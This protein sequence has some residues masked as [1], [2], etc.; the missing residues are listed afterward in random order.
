VVSFPQDVLESIQ[1]R[2]TDHMVDLLREGLQQ[3]PRDVEILS[4]LGGL[5]T[6]AGL[7]EEGL[8]IDLRL[9]QLCPEDPIVHYNLGCSLALMGRIDEAF[10]AIEAALD[11]GYEDL[12]LLHTD[13]DLSNLRKDARFTA[14]VERW[15]SRS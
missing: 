4:A 7:L 13:P 11:L 8:E 12:Q 1:R 6:T 3:R 15:S 2:A 5:L 9:T 14:F 10:R